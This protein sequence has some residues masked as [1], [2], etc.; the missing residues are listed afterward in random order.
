MY[1]GIKFHSSCWG[2]IAVYLIVALVFTLIGPV[3]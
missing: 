3:R 1:H 2:I